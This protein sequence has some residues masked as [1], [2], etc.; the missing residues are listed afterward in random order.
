M[1]V[2]DYCHCQVVSACYRFSYLSGLCLLVAC[3]IAARVRHAA[4]E[5]QASIY[6]E[7]YLVGSELDNLNSGGP[8]QAAGRAHQG[9]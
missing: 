8:G 5:L 6:N 2:C 4:A 3:W 1:V 7:R 9:A